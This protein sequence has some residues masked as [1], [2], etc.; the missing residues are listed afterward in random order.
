MDPTRPHESAR[1]SFPAPARFAT[2]AAR[3]LSRSHSSDAT[4]YERR[5]SASAEHLTH[6][7]EALQG[8]EQSYTDAA[9]ALYEEH[10]RYACFVQEQ[11]LSQPPPP[12]S[13]SSSRSRSHPHRTSL[14]THL[15]SVLVDSLRSFCDDHRSDDTASTATDGT[16]D[17]SM[18][19]EDDDDDDGS[20]DALC[21]ICYDQTATRTVACC[22]KP[23]CGACLAH[24]RCATTPRQG[25]PWCRQNHRLQCREDGPSR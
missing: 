14:P 19:E 5:C 6:A 17:E 13:G 20:V 24:L 2:M 16:V 7:L 12:V 22:G 1:D 4:A 21:L 3:T 9:A 10:V 11:I 18:M 25:C 23:L 15:S 8:A